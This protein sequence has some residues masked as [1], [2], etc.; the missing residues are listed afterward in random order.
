MF[1]F[2]RARFFILTVSLLIC[3][4]EALPLPVGMPKGF[5]RPSGVST[6]SLAVDRRGDLLLSAG[7]A[8]WR[9]ELIC[10]AWAEKGGVEGSYR[11]KISLAGERGLIPAVSVGA[12][13]DPFLAISKRINPPLLG[14]ISLHL[15]LW[16]RDVWAGA[17]KW[18]DP[19]GIDLRFELGVERGSDGR[20]L[21]S[22]RLES[23]EGSRIGLLYERGSDRLW[24][25]VGFSSEELISG[26]RG[27]ERL[28]REAGK[29]AARA[30][31]RGD[32]PAGR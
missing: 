21:A 18:F 9:V 12:D 28:A 6:L 10:R 16:G 26:L 14:P 31:R 32:Q 23:G 30:L 29:L 17:C 24:F 25:E 22:I 27:A 8:V 13:G 1:G 19:P 4:R 2:G 15:A 5:A 11:A 20:T 3:S 7:A